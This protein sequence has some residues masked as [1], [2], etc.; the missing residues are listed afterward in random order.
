MP[1][2]ANKFDNTDTRRAEHVELGFMEIDEERV[3]IHAI[4]KGAYIKF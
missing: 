3:W 2:V 1:R 4:V